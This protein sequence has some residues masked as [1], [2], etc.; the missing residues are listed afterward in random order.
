VLL[1][2]DG[3]GRII[4]IDGRTFD[5]AVSIFRLFVLDASTQAFQFRLFDLNALILAFQFRAFDPTLQFQNS[6]SNQPRSEDVIRSWKSA[7]RSLNDK[8]AMS[9]APRLKCAR[10]PWAQMQ[11]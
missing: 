8:I 4:S 2:L 3:L 1:N 7:K 11:L 5:S 6:I 10:K 9:L